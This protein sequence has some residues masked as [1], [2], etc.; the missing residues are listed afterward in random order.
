[1]ALYEMLG[2]RRGVTAIIGS[3]G[4]TSLI[5]QLAK[6][7]RRHGTVLILT[8]TKMCLPASE[9]VSCTAQEAK[10]AL[11][12]RG[13]AYLGE[14]DRKLGKL[15]PPG[16]SGWETL[17]DYVLTESDGAAGLPLKAHAAWEPVL[18]KRK[19]QAISVVGASGIGNPILSAVHRPEIFCRLC[20]VKIS[21]LATPE[22]IAQVLK[23][24]NL[25]DRVFINQADTADPEG[26]AQLASLLPWPVVLGSLKNSTWKKIQ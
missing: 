5:E 11:R 2:I 14:P 19:T 13:L 9:P 8:T 23:E 16:F 1:M 6:E 26:P 21:E 7:L 12:E 24:E 3:G 10:S 17:A 20:G 22:R 25:S 15:L 18:P 4:K